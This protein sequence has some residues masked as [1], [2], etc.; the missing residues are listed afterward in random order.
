MDQK[1]DKLLETLLSSPE[2][3]SALIGTIVDQYK[4]FVY[5]VA[6]EG[7]KVYK[8]FANNKEYF[9]TKAIAKKNEFD[10]YV[11]AGFTEEQAMSMLLTA[12]HQQQEMI[13][14]TASKTSIKSGK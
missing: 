3:S 8:D 4:P 7:L 1:M 12:M 11:N 2:T 6:K 13:Q 10:A 14:K 5:A 9:E